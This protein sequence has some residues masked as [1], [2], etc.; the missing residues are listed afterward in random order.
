VGQHRQKPALIPAHR[1]HRRAVTLRRRIHTHERAGTPLLPRHRV[2]T[3]D[4]APILSRQKRLLTLLPQVEMK[5]SERPRPQ[6]LTLLLVVDVHL[7]RIAQPSVPL[8]L[9]ALID[10][11]PQL[12]VAVVGNV[13]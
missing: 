12:A 4:R 8:R 1:H 13:S 5:T 7:G 2:L 10:I 6:R 9:L 3:R 11:R